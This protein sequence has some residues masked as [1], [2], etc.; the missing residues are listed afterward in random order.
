VPER[1]IVA[2]DSRAQRPAHRWGG[3]CTQ[4][5]LFVFFCL[6]S[7][8]ASREAIQARQAARQAAFDT[9]DDNQCRAYGAQPGTKPYIDCRMSL[10]A[11]RAQT[12][13]MRE[14]HQQETYRQMMITGAEM[15][16]GR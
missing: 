3:R 14:A 15:M 13:A 6:L 12:E 5:H 11:L 2:S 8:C 7:G 4:S 1:L 10:H 9:A 16:S